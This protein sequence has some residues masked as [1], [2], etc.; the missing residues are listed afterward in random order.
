MAPSCTEVR[1]LS[2]AEVRALACAVVKAAMVG[3]IHDLLRN[4]GGQQQVG[5][6]RVVEQVPV[7][8]PVDPAEF[9][10]RFRER[11]AEEMPEPADEVGLNDLGGLPPEPET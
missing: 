5:T 11:M 2:W 10:R 8:G 3:A 1:A 9:A 4:V 6:R 7:E